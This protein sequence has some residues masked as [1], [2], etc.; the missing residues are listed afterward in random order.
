MQNA[1]IV[2]STGMGDCL[3]GTPGPGLEED[4]P[5][6]EDWLDSELALEAFIRGKQPE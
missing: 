5:R 6:S 3:W 1:L 2:S 4:I